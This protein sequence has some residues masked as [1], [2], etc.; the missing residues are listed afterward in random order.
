MIIIDPT[1]PS[2]LPIARSLPGTLAAITV[3]ALLL[4][5]CAGDRF[6]QRAPAWA[7]TL[8]STEATGEPAPE[9]VKDRIP[10]AG[11]TSAPSMPDP[12]FVRKGTGK[13]VDVPALTGIA[14]ARERE[15]GDIKLNF[16]QANLLEVVKVVLGDMLGVN[17]IVDPGLR[18]VVSMQTTRA[19]KRE[20]LLPTL[21]MLLRMNDAALIVDKGIYH[22]VPL[23]K[24]LVEAQSPQLGDSSLALPAGFSVKIVPLEF[25][26]AEEMAQIL[27]P[28]VAGSNQLL[29][30]DSGRNLLILAAASGEMERL[31]DMIDVFDVD[32]MKGM[33]VALFTPDFTD[34]KTLSEDLKVLLSDP[35]YGLM[36]GLVRLIVVPRLNG[37]I[38]VTPKPE[39]LAAVRGWVERLDRNSGDASQ[40][41][42]VYRVQNGKATEL[43]D[44][45]GRLFNPDTNKEK[46]HE[47]DAVVAPGLTKV[48]I[49]DQPEE[50]RANGAVGGKSAAKKNIAGGPGDGKGPLKIDGSAK[51]QIIAD[52]P[53]NALLILAK[54]S[55]YRQILTALRQLDVSPMQVLIE[56]TIA[57]VTLTD[58]LSFGVEWYFRNHFGS[59]SGLGTLD[60]GAK[61]IGAIQPGFSY[62]LLGSGG[63]VQAVLNA[64]ST[65]SNLSVISSPSLLVLNNQ[66]AAIQVG[67]EVPVAVQQ[68]QSTVGNSSIINSIDYRETGVMLKVKPRINAGGLVIMDVEQEASQVPSTNNA[69]PLTPRIRQRKINSTVAVNSGDTIIL[70]GLIQDNRDRSESGVPFLHTLPL[71]GPLFGTKADNQARTELIVLITPRA[72][73]NSTAA[74]QVTEAFRRRLQKLIPERPATASEAIS[75]QES[76]TAASAAE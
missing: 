15:G 68:E 25:V 36:P 54:G 59:Q 42:F 66:E 43:A 10:G 26:A 53:N 21:E 18:G 9:T 30:V 27:E 20:D 46:T 2:R 51:V 57:E 75:G 39:H 64:L 1:A 76:P 41:L 37:L 4:S 63:A 47:Q 6:A 24:A 11:A 33:S 56:V 48:T 31:L 38:V 61:G 62:A 7:D 73:T 70:G 67:D 69:D 32:R 50:K 72:V 22:V 13:L 29:R 19:I 5:G 28:F 49:G 8:R 44:I 3:L 52:E 40:R 65:E 14:D 17:Y 34:A 35:I 55:D 60:L 16:Q 58:N 71:V 74:M 12:E 23:A 45:L